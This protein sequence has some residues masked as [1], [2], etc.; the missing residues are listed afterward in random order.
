MPAFCSASGPPMPDSCSRCGERIAPAERNHLTRR[1]D[2]LEAGLLRELD[3][4]R[5]LAIEHNPMHLRVGED[6]QIR[7][8]FGGAEIGGSGA[9]AAA[10]ASGLLAPADRVSGTTWQVVDVGHV[11]EAEFLRR[12]DDRVTSLRLL[13]HR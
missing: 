1:V 13:G 4:D 11:F 7:P 10:P 3:A 8:L 6:L 12:P 9:G 5:A 2:T